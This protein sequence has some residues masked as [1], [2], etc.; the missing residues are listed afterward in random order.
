MG[1]RK[2][3]KNWL[4]KLENNIRR[5]MFVWIIVLSITV[6]ALL[7]IIIF[8]FPLK[9]KEPYLVFFSQADQNFVRVEKA[10]GDY[11][12]QRALI[13]SLVAAYVQKR[14]TINRIDDIPR[15]EDIRLQS[16]S[17]VW[18]QFE[19]L[20]R[21][22]GSV[23]QNNSIKRNIEVVNVSLVA[24][25]IAQID[26][27]ARVY[28]AGSLQSV[29]RRRATLAYVFDDQEITFNNIPKN[30]TGFKVIG[31][32]ITEVYIPQDDNKNQKDEK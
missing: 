2:I 19:K 18:G 9:E 12:S 15:Y 3:D 20:V 8:L 25:N 7:I 14:E 6:I 1:D 31:Y 30:P 5:L 16:S 27:I 28:Y 11:K 23:Y 10:N 13:Y 22:K 29:K 17:E 32:E 24:K 26:F 4:F 21:Q